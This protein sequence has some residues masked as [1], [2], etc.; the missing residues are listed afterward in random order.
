MVTEEENQWLLMKSADGLQSNGDLTISRPES[1]LTKRKNNDLR[2]GKHED[3]NDRRG[4][5]SSFAKSIKVTSRN[6]KAG[7]TTVN[8][9]VKEGQRIC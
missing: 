7:S 2:I 5:G 6:K 9:Q 1:V 8:K 4:K 3:K